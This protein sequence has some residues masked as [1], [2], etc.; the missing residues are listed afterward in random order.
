M[1]ARLFRFRFT[2]SLPRLDTLTCPAG[3]HGPP[4]LFNATNAAVYGEWFG[5]RYAGLPKIVGADSDRWW[6]T[7][8]TAYN[9]ARAKNAGQTSDV[10]GI[11]QLPFADTG[12][13]W[14]ALVGGLLK[15]ERDTSRGGPSVDAFVTYHPTNQWLAQ[16]PAAMGSSS[17]P[18]ASWLK[19][20]AVQSG[21]ESIEFLPGT[22]RWDA[23][24][25][26]VPVE[27]MYNSSLHRKGGRIPVQDLEN[28]YEG[29]YFNI[30]PTSPRI[31]NASDV[32]NGA[33][34]AVSFHSRAVGGEADVHRDRVDRFSP[35]Q[36]ARRTAR[37]R[38]GSSGTRRCTRASSR[39]PHGRNNSSSPAAGSSSTYR[40]S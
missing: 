31:W 35:A 1:E 38:S 34:T 18:N 27:I 14:E 9:V 2:S 32:R 36:R 7:N 10:G 11:G 24:K 30:D 40:I 8:I 23:Q 25:N 19:M 29:G 22:G 6:P 3:W 16:T 17:F 20:D 26:Y 37:G 12:D 5:R 21:H 13:V 28:H 33:W 39:R 4:I 15:A